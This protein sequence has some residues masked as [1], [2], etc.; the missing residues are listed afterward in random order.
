M[1]NVPV[2]EAVLKRI[3]DEL[4]AANYR[5]MTGQGIDDFATYRYSIGVAK[6]LADAN[7]I[8]VQVL[9]ALGKPEEEAK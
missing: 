6:G 4:D 2:F 1:I 5:I 8:I 9:E 7:A 3:N